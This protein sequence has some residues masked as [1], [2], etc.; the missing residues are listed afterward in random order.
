[1]NKSIYFIF[2]IILS[3]S[4]LS[5]TPLILEL[6]IESNEEDTLLEQED[7]FQDKDPD[8]EN[9]TTLMLETN[10]PDDDE[11]IADQATITLL[12]GTIEE[13][14]SEQIRNKTFLQLEKD[15]QNL[16]K[17]HGLIDL[18]ASAHL[19][20]KTIEDEISKEYVLKQLAQSTDRKLYSINLCSSLHL[21]ET[22]KD[23][24]I[25]NSDPVLFFT[26]LM[27][28]YITQTGIP[29]TALISTLDQAKAQGKLIAQ[30][31]H[32]QAEIFHIL[33]TQARTIARTC[34]Q[35]RLQEINFGS[36]RLEK[37]CRKKLLQSLH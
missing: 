17:N 11:E 33:A 5:C 37:N 32:E 13:L 30:F 18:E 1:M 35:N 24:L 2:A 8:D 16:E 19:D 6:P 10:D 3:C 23:F 20:V 21:S 12:L 22:T 26:D 4:P 36:Y 27:K 14:E 34:V 31:M 29:D 15:L 7:M 25:K 9:I 28:N